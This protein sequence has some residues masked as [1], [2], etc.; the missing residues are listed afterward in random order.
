MLNAQGECL[1]PQSIPPSTKSTYVYD[2]NGP[3]KVI[4][5]NFH[6]ISKTNGTGN[7]TETN[8]GYYNPTPRSYNGYMYADDM[9]KWCNEHWNINEPLLHM[10]IPA[11]PALP[12]KIKFQLCGVYF[13]KSDS[14]YYTYDLADS[15]YPP[16]VENTGEVINIFITKEHRTNPSAGGVAQGLGIGE[17]TK[18][19]EAYSY[20]KTAIDS[21]AMWYVSVPRKVINHEVGHLL[22]LSHVVVNCCGYSTADCDGISDTPTSGW[23]IDHGFNNDKPCCWDC[24]SKSNNLMD[25]SNT[26]GALSPM[27]IARVHENIDIPRLYYRNCKFQTQSLNITNFSASKAYIAKKVTIPSGYNIVVNNNQALFINAEEF[28]ING[29]FEVQLGSVFSVETNPSCD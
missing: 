15:N 25:Y 6:F 28:T 19:F 7:F 8:D 26:M 13:H 27:Q 21:N 10:P 3:V 14:D 20:Y 1:T 12:K 29:Q 22:N 5:V 18:I 23:L 9:I 16:Y 4:R 24:P 2:P 17:S 11:V